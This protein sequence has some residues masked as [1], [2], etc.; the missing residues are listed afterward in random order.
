[1]GTTMTAALSTADGPAARPR[2]RLARLPPARG[3]LRQVTDDHSLVGETGAPGPVDG[4]AGGGPSPPQRDH[5]GLG[6]GAPGGPGHHPL[7]LE[8]GDRVLFCSDGL[9]GMVADEELAR[10]LGEGDH[11]QTVADALV[12]AALAGAA[13]TTS[14]SWWCWRWRMRSTKGRRRTP[15]RPARPLRNR[16]L[17]CSDR[18]IALRHAQR[19]PQDSRLR[20][21][22]GRLRNRVVILVVGAALVVLLAGGV[23]FA[24]FNSTV[25]FVGT[26]A[27]AGWPCTTACPAASS[28][29]SSTRWWRWPHRRTQALADYV[30][31]ARGR[32]RA[33]HARRRGSASSAVWRR[34]Q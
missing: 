8:P 32:P 26:Y 13:R 1:M 6:H 18:R 15:G 31:G 12:E 33:D 29:A 4:G 24:L 2:G 21:G 3:E 9:S 16:R 30:Q 23:G 34:Q 20:R 27:T 7:A 14:P 5:P 10:V 19:E 17:R 28:G 11:P 25:Y 22:L